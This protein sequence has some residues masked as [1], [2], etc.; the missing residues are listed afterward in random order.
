MVG[1]TQKKLWG[2]IFIVGPYKKRKWKQKQ[3]EYDLI[4]T[5]VM[6]QLLRTFRN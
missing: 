4:G 6:N 3:I 1:I 5:S 2:F